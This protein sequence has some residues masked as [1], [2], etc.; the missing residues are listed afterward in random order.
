M[1]IRYKLG[2]CGPSL[3]LMRCRRRPATLTADIPPISVSSWGAGKPSGGV[4]VTRRHVVI[5]T[6]VCVCGVCVHYQLVEAVW[7]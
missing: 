4:F 5:A 3:Y 1:A 6:R 2:C 7:R